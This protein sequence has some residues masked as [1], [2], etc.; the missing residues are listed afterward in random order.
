MIVDRRH[1]VMGIACLAAAGSAMALKPRRRLSLGGDTKLDAVIPRRFGGWTEQPTEA[2]ITPEDEDGLAARLYSQVVGRLYVNGEG[3][4]VMLLIAYGDTQNDLLQLHRPEVCYPAFG[5]AITG[6][7]KTQI[8]LAHNVAIPARALTASSAQRV[9]Q[10]LYWSRIGEHL[11]TDG[12]EQRLAKLEDQFAGIVPDGILVR[13]SVIDEDAAE[14]LALNRSF[15]MELMNAIPAS[16]R[17]MLIGTDAATRLAALRQ[18]TLKQSDD[19]ALMTGSAHD[20]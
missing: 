3:A 17:P 4:M 8:P 14:G 13:I 1:V 16:N 15:A 18:R 2:L 19:R 7:G 20:G 12:R 5:F 6:S 9:E 11:P 10:I